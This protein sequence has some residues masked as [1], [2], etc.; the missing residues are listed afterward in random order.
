M[1]L[2][3]GPRDPGTHWYQCRLLLL[4]PLAV[5]ATQVVTGTV[6]MKA[7]KKFS[8]DITLTV[9]LEGT[10]ITSVNHIC[11]DNQMYHY[12]QSPAA[13]EPAAQ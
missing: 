12:L 13:A 1:K 5:N 10:G 11:L 4:D 8:Y 7:N 2:S 3:T 6:S 9:E